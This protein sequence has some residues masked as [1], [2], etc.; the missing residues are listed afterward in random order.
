MDETTTALN[1]QVHDI[2]QQLISTRN[3]LSE[4]KESYEQ[5]SKE[6]DGALQRLDALSQTNKKLRML[7][8]DRKLD[9][10][11]ESSSGIASSINTA[12]NHKIETEDSY[13]DAL[14]KE[15]HDDTPLM[16][17]VLSNAPIE[18]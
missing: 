17:A 18:F 11:L 8:A 7:M 3:H 2:E 13:G 9:G 12:T 6:H 5:L 15:H 10:Y 1:R 16:R 14:L 4:Y